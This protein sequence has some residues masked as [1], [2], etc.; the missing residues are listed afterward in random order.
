MATPP[1][2]PMADGVSIGPGSALATPPCAW[3]GLGYEARPPQPPWRLSSG[4]AP[5]WLWSQVQGFP[6]RVGWGAGAMPASAIPGVPGAFVRVSVTW[7]PVTFDLRPS[8]PLPR[9]PPPHLRCG[10]RHRPR[11]QRAPGER[12]RRRGRLRPGRGSGTGHRAAAGRLGERGRGAE[13]EARRLPGGRVAGPRCQ[14]PAGASAG[15]PVTASHSPRPGPL[16][17]L[18]SASPSLP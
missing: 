15:E 14:A 8:S 4:S 17:S 11:D 16:W 2:W 10:Q 1:Q 7:R 5:R 18:V 6:P 9:T 13:R 3:I 12:G